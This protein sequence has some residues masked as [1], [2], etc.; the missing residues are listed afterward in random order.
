MTTE[1]ILVHA[2]KCSDEQAQYIVYALKQWGASKI[3]NIEQTSEHY[4]NI[5]C[6]EGELFLTFYKEQ[7]V[8]RIESHDYNNNNLILYM[9]DTVQAALIS[10][11]TEGKY[12][13]DTTASVISSI[14]NMLTVVR[15]KTYQ[16][17]ILDDGTER[18]LTPLAMMGEILSAAQQMAPSIYS[19]TYMPI[20]PSR[21]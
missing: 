7:S 1:E 15:Y 21:G 10:S 14:E 12:Y 19:M 18:N 9:D 5:T 6:P 3:Q 2:M 17:I 13:L 4:W 20:R 16:G 11:D 8:L